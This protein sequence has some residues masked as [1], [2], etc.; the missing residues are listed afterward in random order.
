MKAQ[1]MDQLFQRLI[2]DGT[3]YNSSDGGDVWKYKGTKYTVRFSTIDGQPVVTS[4]RNHDTGV[5]FVRE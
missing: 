5:T 3:F 1:F 2:S 4:M